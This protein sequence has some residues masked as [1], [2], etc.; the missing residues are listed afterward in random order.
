MGDLKPLALVVDEEKGTFLKAR[1]T[2]GEFTMTLK[3]VIFYHGGCEYVVTESRTEDGFNFRIL[4]K[5]R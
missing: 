1:I 3:D 4:L 2:V 5:R